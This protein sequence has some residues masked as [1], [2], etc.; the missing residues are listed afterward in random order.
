MKTNKNDVGSKKGSH[1]GPVISK[2]QYDK[3]INLMIVGIPNVGKSTF[4]NTLAQRKLAPVAN[5][6]AYTRRQQY[7]SLQKQNMQLVDT[8]GLLWPKINEERVG[9][10]LAA[11]KNIGHNAYCEEDV[12]YFVMDRLIN[13]YPETILKRYGIEIG[14]RDKI[15]LLESIAIKKNFFCK[16]GNP[17]LRK[18]ATAL[19]NDYRSGRLG[20]IS[21][22]R[23]FDL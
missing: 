21:L 16:G 18:A 7:T 5:I 6:P 17:A 14:M 2:T 20:R 22:E 13:D 9:Y 15:E 12:G 1:I 11:N 19:L 8:P 3:I 10:L 4:F 23:P